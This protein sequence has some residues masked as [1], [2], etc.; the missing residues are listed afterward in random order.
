LNNGN[1]P[2][3]RP[4]RPAGFSLGGAYQD[5]SPHY[6]LPEFSLGAASLNASSIVMSVLPLIGSTECCS[7]VSNTP[8]SGD[9]RNIHRSL[10]KDHVE[11]TKELSDVAGLLRAGDRRTFDEGGPD[12]NLFHQG[13]AKESTDRDVI[14]VTMA[15]PGVVL[16]RPVGS[17]G[18]FGEHAALPKNLGQSGGN[19]A[20]SKP[21]SREAKKS[22][23][24][25]DKAADRKAA[26]AYERERD[27]RERE[28]AKEKAIQEKERE[29]RRQAVFKAQASLDLAEREHDERSATLRAQIEVIEKTLR[30]EDAGWDKEEGRLKGALRRARDQRSID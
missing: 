11:E 16:K 14:A 10:R 22:S 25:P 5:L 18:P 7:L 20:A 24:R 21:P 19:K 3:A 9:R 1:I 6:N 8:C 4:V 27:R 15:K 29:R 26:Q 12:S 28:E 30:A 23:A 13:G 17:D 2:L